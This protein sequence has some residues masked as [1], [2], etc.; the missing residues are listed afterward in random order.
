MNKNHLQGLVFN[1]VKVALPIAFAASISAC[2]S[3]KKVDALVSN[4][5]L[6]CQ[7]A[8]NYSG[9]VVGDGHCVSLIKR[10]S[11]APT[12]ESWYPGE[13][14]LDSSIPPGTVIATFDN[15]RYPN[16][17]GH[18]AAIYIGQDDRGIWVWDQWVGKPVHKRLIRIRGDNANAGNTA[19]A[20]RVVQTK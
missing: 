3:S 2:A 15:G 11:G 13:K 9:Q 16:R 19:Q 18:H 7:S 10:C 14:V 1:S 6:I 12:T 5:Y 4:A 17:T 20:Y 8:S